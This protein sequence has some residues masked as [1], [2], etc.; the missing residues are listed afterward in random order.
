MIGVGQLDLAADILQIVGGDRPL[1]GALGP[2]VHEHG[3]LGGAMGAGKDT[4]AGPALGFDHFKHRK[5]PLFMGIKKGLQFGFSQG[6]ELFFG[7]SLH[8]PG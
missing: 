6:R 5:T 3:G 8:R 7:Q 4:S 1:D 2:Y